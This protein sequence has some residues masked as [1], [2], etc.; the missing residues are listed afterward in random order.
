MALHWGAVGDVP[1]RLEVFTTE[2]K[3]WCAAPPRCAL[4]GSA[5]L[6]EM[7]RMGYMCSRTA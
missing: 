6:R 7:Q 5:L 3:V 2:K 4:G 1:D